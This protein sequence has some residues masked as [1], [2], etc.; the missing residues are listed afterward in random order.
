MGAGTVWAG[1][2]SCL[3]ACAEARWSSHPTGHRPA[4]PGYG[5]SEPGPTTRPVWVN[6]GA[7]SPA[8]VCADGGEQRRHASS[9]RPH[10]SIRRGAEV[11][12]CL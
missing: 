6:C 1:L 8:C 2:Q 4:E 12:L 5:G 7:F 9:S 10:I 3:L 11:G